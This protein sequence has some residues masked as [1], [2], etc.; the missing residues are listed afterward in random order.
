MILIDTGPLVAL[1][2]KG[3]RETH[4][5]CTATFRSL[6]MPLLTTWPCLTEAMHFLGGVRGWQ[7]QAV[8]WRFFE[9]GA[10]Q[11]HHP[12]PDEWVR[13]RALMEQYQDTPMD[14]AD[15]SLV[16]LAEATGVKQIFTLDSDFFIYR[17]KGKDVF[18]IIS[19]DSA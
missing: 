2:D 8:L 10:L 9:R 1:I 15:A 3:D 6:R 5:K 19:L 18:D 11:L 16:W 7:S 12:Q 14:I 17:I 4:R 13:I